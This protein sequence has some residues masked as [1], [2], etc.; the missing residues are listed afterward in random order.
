[1]TEKETVR[2]WSLMTLTLS[3]VSFGLI[4]IF[5]QLFV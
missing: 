1:L 4:L 5:W 3:L 2:S